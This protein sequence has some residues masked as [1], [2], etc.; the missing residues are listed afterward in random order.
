M[1]KHF[2]DE[3]QPANNGLQKQ[4]TLPDPV[5]RKNI[6]TLDMSTWNGLGIRTAACR[7]GCA[8]SLRSWSKRSVRIQ[9]DLASFP[10]WEQNQ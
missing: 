1:A 4:I 6:C 2:N 7:N 5:K 3:A 9:K 10:V 8:G